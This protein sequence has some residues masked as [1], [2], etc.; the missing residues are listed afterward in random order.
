LPNNT[1]FIECKWVFKTKI[2]SLGNIEKYKA[3]F[4]A[5]GFIQNKRTNYKE[6]FSLISKKDSLRIILVLEAYFDLEMQ[7]MNVKT[8][9]L[10]ED[11]EEEVYMKQPEGFSSSDDENLVCTLKKSIYSLKQVSQ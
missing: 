7:R 2:N 6:T 3:R 8:I 11:L 4:V 9:F 10:N 5:K 1:R